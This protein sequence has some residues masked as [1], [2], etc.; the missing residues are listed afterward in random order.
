[1]EEID[2]I[3][4]FETSKYPDKRSAAA[5]AAAKR[6]T[7][8]Q[9]KAAYYEM[10][11]LKGEAFIEQDVIDIDLAPP[12]SSSQKKSIAAAVAENLTKKIK[13]SKFDYEF[14]K[15]PYKYITEISTRS[16]M[17]YCRIGD[18]GLDA[19]SDVLRDDCIL[20][21]I[22]LA[23]AHISFKGMYVCIYMLKSIFIF[24]HK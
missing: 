3:V 11:R 17:K 1:M 4:Y 22:V 16:N 9:Q 20:R 12:S 18:S 13:P 24:K 7:A 19:L 21:S 10:L 23:N 8:A 15:Y 6:P 5:I 14:I 2:E